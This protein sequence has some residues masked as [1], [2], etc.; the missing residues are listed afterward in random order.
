LPSPRGFGVSRAF[1]RAGK[2]L[3][4]QILRQLAFVLI[5][6]LQLALPGVIRAFG[7]Q[8]VVRQPPQL[9]V[10]GGLPMLQGLFRR[11]ASSDAGA[12]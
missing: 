8:A 10:D 5:R 12:R 6:E 1:G 3:H 4:H 9:F 11:P 7:L 2:F